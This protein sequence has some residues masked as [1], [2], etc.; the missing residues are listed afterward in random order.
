[1]PDAPRPAYDLV[2]T[3]GRV[4]DPGRGVDAVLDVAVRDGRIARVAPGIGAAAGVRSVDARGRIVTPGLID[5]H[6]HIYHMGIENGL[7][8]DLAG[9]RSG[10]TTLVDGGSA[11]SANYEGFSRHVIAKAA[12]RVLANIH[13]AR[14]GLAFMPE[15][16]DA[17][18]ID[19]DATVE[20]IARHRGEIIGVKVR[21]LGPAARTLGVAYIEKAVAAA[22]E[23]GVRVMV[24]IGDP[25]DRAPETANLTRALLPL[26]EP[27][28]I[29]T[30]LFTGA[31]GKALDTLG[32]AVPELVEAKD[33]GVVF[34]PAHGRFNLSFEVAKRM[35]DQDIIPYTISTD[36][37]RQ[38]H[39]GRVRS[40]T[41]IMGKFLALGYSLSEVIRMSTYNPAR[42]VG[43]QE[44]LG[45]LAEG[46]TADIAILEEATGEWDYEDAEAVMI[47]GQK[48]LCP[49]LTFKGGVQYSPDYGPFPWGW[50]PNPVR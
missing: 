43:R 23:A 33:R 50:L 40:M 34:D 46:T 38:G 13:I 27:D 28:D 39:A 12:T 11:G 24:H 25:A 29:L 1:M 19:H 48:A 10:V 6:A 7:D 26:L 44:D 3:G 16:R 49:V 45:T 36:I 31:P 18:D 4:L 47:Q 22:R 14:A 5:V 21:A 20:A 35:M 41:H 9:V 8:P 32:R 17:S 30:H 42:L 37:T 15:A 2:I